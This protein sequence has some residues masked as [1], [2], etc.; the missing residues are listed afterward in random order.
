LIG[1]SGSGKSDQ[2]AKHEQQLFHDPISRHIPH[3]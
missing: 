3:W 1:N 2:E